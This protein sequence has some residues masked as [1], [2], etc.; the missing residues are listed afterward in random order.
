MRVRDITFGAKLPQ[1]AHLYRIDIDT[2]EII[3]SIPTLTKAIVLL[4]T[5]IPRWLIPIHDLI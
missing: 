3:K 2:H 4:N 5:L 1:F